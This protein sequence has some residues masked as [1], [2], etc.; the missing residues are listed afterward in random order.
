M[1]LLFLTERVGVGKTSNFTAGVGDTGHV[2]KP[3]RAKTPS[4]LIWWAP[5]SG[6]FGPISKSSSQ[7]HHTT[8]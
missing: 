1:Y 6:S 7:S 2:F 5:H 4:P 3:R 8:F